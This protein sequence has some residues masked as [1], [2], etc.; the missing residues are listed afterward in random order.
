M[1]QHQLGVSGSFV[2]HSMWF[3]IREAIMVHKQTVLWKGKKRNDNSVRHEE[4]WS[5][6]LMQPDPDCSVCGGSGYIFSPDTD[7]EAILPAYIT[8]KRPHGF[9]GGAGDL[10]TT[11]GRQTRV[12]AVMYMAGDVG[13][14]IET[15][16]LIIFPYR[17]TEYE[18]VEFTVITKIPNFV[19]GDRPIFYEFELFKSIRSEVLNETQ[20]P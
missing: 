12:D 8:H 6:T 15:N 11:A 18:K 17:D 20:I 19:F 13:R 3:Y 7:S 10:H 4:C 2:P 5:E 16:D 9:Q 1:S 14:K